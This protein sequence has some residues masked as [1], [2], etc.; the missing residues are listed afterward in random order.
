MEFEIARARIGA[1]T[2]FTTHKPATIGFRIR[3]RDGR[4][5]HPELRGEL[6]LRR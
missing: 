2:N 5:R 6:A 1:A 3:T 4:K